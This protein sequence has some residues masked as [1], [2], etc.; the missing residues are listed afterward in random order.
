VRVPN[1]G[2]ASRTRGLT[3]FLHGRGGSYTEPAV[4]HDKLLSQFGDKRQDV[5]VSPLGRRRR[6]LVHGRGRVRLLRGLARRQRHFA[7][8]ANRVALSGY[9]MGGYATYRLGAL[10]PDLFGR[11]FTV[12]GPPA[13]GRWVPPAHPFD[14]DSGRFTEDTNSNRLLENVRWI[15]YLNSG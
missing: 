4:F 13:R 2:P 11:A 9:S 10:Y 1:A 15:P 14:P 6:R 3:W 7:I 12:V 8:D 5:V